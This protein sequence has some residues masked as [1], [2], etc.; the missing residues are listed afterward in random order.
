MKI[1]FLDSAIIN[2]GDISWEGLQRF[3]E[4]EVRKRTSREEAVS[5]IGDAEAV[6]TDSFAI[7]R[8]LMEACPSLKFIGISATGFNHVDLDAAKELGIAVANVPAYAAEAVAQH[9]MALLLSVTNQIEAYNAAVKA[10]EWQKSRDYTFIKAPLT[11][12]AG[13]SIGIVGFGDIGSK[14]AQIAEAL[15]MK[16]NIYS[17]D[18]A[19]AIG[20]DVVSLSCPLTPEN[21]GMVDA[22]FISQMK[23]GAI[24][25]NTAR[26]GLIDETALADALKSGKIAGAG[27]DVLAQEP[28]STDNPLVGIPNCYITPHI[29]FI[30]VETRRV[31]IETCEKNLESFIE[32][33]SLNR[34]V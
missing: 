6:F 19:A 17:R 7:D 13:K 4:L 29:G 8:E 33:V 20:S 12:L 32:G 9:A 28:P 18:K 30:P 16:V 22:E 21:R 23:D 31:V 11:L 25:I 10:G 1:V 15:G 24:L 34:L 26:G 14:I 3:G 5:V 2:P 27:L